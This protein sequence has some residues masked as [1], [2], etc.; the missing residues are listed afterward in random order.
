M[1]CDLCHQDTSSS[2]TPG[3]IQAAGRKIGDHILAPLETHMEAGR[4][5][6]A[7]NT[8]RVGVC[9]CSVQPGRAEAALSSVLSTGALLPKF[10]ASVPV[11]AKLQLS[12]RREELG[13]KQRS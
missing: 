5:F 8:G 2:S 6:R 1:A 12:N 3:R 13:C 10:P 11:T 7:R 9:H 4:G